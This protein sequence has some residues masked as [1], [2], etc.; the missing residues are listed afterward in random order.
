MREENRQAGRG[1]ELLNVKPPRPDQLV[2]NLSGGNQQKVVLAKWLVRDLKLIF[3][4]EPT[5]GIDIGAKEEIYGHIQA[6]S[7][8]GVSVLLVSS[9]LPELIRLSD[10]V[11]VL[12]E[13]R[14]FQEFRDCVITGEKIL[15][16]ASGIREEDDE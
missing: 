1:I 16:S 5:V 11:I 7:A 4:D 9:D 6:L 3:I 8:K 10:R 13:G 14:F 12:R 15:R 2:G